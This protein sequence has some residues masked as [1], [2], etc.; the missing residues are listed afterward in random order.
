M[1]KEDILILFQQQKLSL[2]SAR[3]ALERARQARPLPLSAMQ[4][5]IWALQQGA[6]GNTAYQVPLVLRLR[7]ALDMPALEAA[8]LDLAL[9][10][11]ILGSTFRA[12]EGQPW[13]HEYSAAAPVIA[14]QA[15]GP[16]SDAALVQVLRDLKAAPL[17][18]AAGAPWRLHVL[19]LAPDEH[20]LMLVV[21]HIVYDGAS[22]LPLAATLLD[23]H[24][25]RRRGEL[26]LCVPDHAGFEEYVAAERSWMDSAAAAQALAYWQRQLDGELPILELPCD[27]PR[28]AV[29][30]SE[31]AV[32]SARLDDGV[33]AALAAAAAGAGV[34]RSVLFLAAFQLMLVRY[35]GQQDLVLGLPMS[36]RAPQQHG[37]VGNFI[38]MVPLRGAPRPD[39]IGADYLRRLQQDMNLARD[40]ARYPLAALVRHLNVPRSASVAPVFQAVF[41]YQNF[42]RQG[43]EAAFGARHQAQFLNIVHQE[44]EAD[45]GLEV[46]EREDA[47]RVNLKYSS[48]LFQAATADRMLQ[49]FLHLLAQLAAEPQRPMGD[50]DMLL[51]AERA[52]MLGAWNDTAA[53]CPE[54]PLAVL[55]EQQA[56]RQPDA[57]A[58]TA[59]GETL[60]Y[61]QLSQRSSALA[62]RLAGGAGRLVGVCM[63][64]S[65]D[66]L[67]ALLGVMKAG[68]AYVPIDPSYP[69]ERMRAI[70]MDSGA[71]CFLADA[72]SLPA[73]RAAAGA[74]AQLLDIADLGLD[75]PA[76]APAVAPHALAYVIYTSGTTG[77]PKGVMVPQRAL[78]NLL[79]SMARQPG[80]AAG[81]RMLALA[82]FAFDMSIPELFLP[83]LTGGHCILAEA[84]AARDPQRLMAALERHQPHLMQATPTTCAMLFEAGWRNPQGTMILCGAEALTE[85]VRQQLIDSG[86]VAWNMYGPTET[87][88]W[89]T[90]AP[91]GAGLPITLGRPLANTQVYIVDERMRLVPPGLDGELCIAGAGV[92]AGYLGQPE[93]SAGRFV[94][95]P[96]AG[97]GKLY[98]TGDI[99]RW[100]PDGQIAFVGR[101]DY[102][103][104]LRG[105]RIELEEVENRLKAHADVE[106]ALV[107]VNQQGKLRRLVAYIVPR[108]AVEP[109][110]LRAWL[111][112]ALPAY[113]V[114]SLYVDLAAIPLNSNG[115]ADRKALMA[116]PVALEAPAPVADGI[117]AE[118][119][120][121]WRRVLKLD[122]IGA[123]HGFFDV[124][125]DSLVAVELAAAISEGM[126]LPFSVTRLFQYACVR[127]I[128][129]YVAQQR[130]QAGVAAAGPAQQAA[131]PAPEADGLAIIGMSLQVP[132]ADSAAAFWSN[133]AAGVESVER[134]EREQLAALGLPAPLLQHERMVGVRAP[135]AHKHS[136]DAEFFGISARDA[137]LMD[138]QF[139]RLL[140]HA[141]LA[142]EDAGY[143]PAALRD[144][145]VFVSASHSEHG[146]LAAAAHGGEHAALDDEGDYVRWILSQGGSI[147]TMISHKLGL[148]GPSLYVHSNC[149]SSLS[150]L[151]AAWHSIRSGEARHALVAAATLYAQ[152]RVGYVHQRGLNFSSDGKLKAFDQDADGMVPGEGVVVL[153]VKRLADAIADDDH[154]YAAIRGVALNNDGADKAGYYAPS[155][156]GQSAVIEGLL[157]S[158]ATD[159]NSVVYVE[160][161]G[162]GTRIGDP[163]EVAALTAAY[164]RLG[165]GQNYC[166]LG[167]VK[168]NLGHLDTAAGLAGL[169]KVALSLYHGSLPPTL[170][171]RQANPALELAGS[172]FYIA[173]RLTPIAG[174]GG[175]VRAAVSAFG[176]GG[177]NGH[178]L[179][180]QRRR[181]AVPAPLG[182]ASHIVPLSAK[183]AQRLLAQVSQLESW[184]AT[185]AGQG[186]ALADI[187]ATLQRG[188]VAMAR[189]VALVAHSH[190]DLAAQLAALAG[191]GLAARAAPED[192]EQGSLAWT[193]WEWESGRLS[194]W[195]TLPAA[196]QRISL[197]GYPFEN[198]DYPPPRRALAAARLHPLLHENISTVQQTAFRSRFDG[199]EPFLRD[200]VLHGQRVLPGAAYLEMVREA[201]SRAV[202]ATG[203]EVSLR[204][205]VWL[206]PL[207]VTQASV[208]VKLA[209]KRLVDGALAFTVS[210][211]ADGAPYCQG[212][213]AV[214]APAAAAA[215][216]DLAHLR[217][218]CQTPRL[219]AQSCYRRYAQL[220]LR[221]GAAHRGVRQVWGDG[222]ELLAQL[223]LPVLDP[224]CMLDPGMLDSAFQ[225]T[226]AIHDGSAAQQAAVPFALEALHVHRACAPRMWAHIRFGPIPAAAGAFRKIDIDLYD[227]EGRLCAAVRQLAARQ[228]AVL[229]A[230]PDAPVL[231]DEATL[232]VAQAR[233]APLA[234][235][236]QPA[237][238]AVHRHVILAGMTAARAQRLETALQGRADLGCTLWP[239]GGAGVAA[240]LHQNTL[241]LVAWLKQLIGQRRAGAQLL[242]LCVE[243]GEAQWA[244][245]ALAAVLKSAMLEYPALRAQL[246]LLEDGAD[247]ALPAMLEQAA[248]QPDALQLRWRGGV[249]ERRALA[250]LAPWAAAP[251]PWRADGVYLITGA[252]GRIA[253]LLA[254]EIA[255]LARGATLVLAGR[256]AQGPR[257]LLDSL[258]QAGARTDYVRLALEDGAQVGAALAGVAA[259]H[260]GLHGVLHCAGALGDS[261]ILNKSEAEVARVLAPKVDGTLHLDA[262]TAA[263][264]LDLFLLFSS[265]G[266][267]LG[268]EGQADYCAANAFLDAFAAEREEWRLRG[269]RHGRS[270]SLG[271]PLWAEGGMRPD[272]AS[273][274]RIERQ[275]GMKPLPSQGAFAALY[276][277]L[278]TPHPS[279]LLLY[280]KAD[281]LQRAL[282]AAAAPAPLQPN[283]QAE[284][285]GKMTMQAVAYPPPAAHGPQ[286]QEAAED[287]F[288]ALLSDVLQTP[289]ARIDAQ[290]PLENYGID[291][292]I[293]VKLNERLEQVFGALSKTLFFEYQTLRAL[294]SYFVEA[295]RGALETLLGR[296]SAAAMPV[297]ATPPA[298][299][300]APA[301]A[302]VSATT[303]QPIP[304]PV[305]AL[306]VA[307]IAIVGL[308]GRYPGAET[309]DAFWRNLRDGVDSIREVPAE[310]WD[311]AAYFH[312]DPGHAGTCYTKWGGFLDGVDC[313][314]AGFFNISPREAAILDPQERV[315]LETAHAAIEDAGYTRHSLGGAARGRPGRVGV[316][317]G[318]MYQEYQLYGAQATAL[319]QVTALPSS[320]S[321][322]ANRVSY[323]CNFQ[324]PSM[325]VDTMCSS[326]LSAIHLA[327]QS[328]RLGE[329]SVALAGG[330]NLSI[331]PNKYL[332]LSLGKFASTKGR[333]ESFGAG[334]DG[335]VPG[336][337]VGAVVL[338]PLAHAL[339]DGDHIYGVIKGSALNHGGK[340]NGFSV[341]NPVAQADV[342]G[343][344]L[345]Q[346]ALAPRALDYIEAHGTGT[347]LGDPIEI[348]GL[349]K[350]F[351]AATQERQFC[352]IGSVKSNIGHCES[353]A[354]MAAL[355]KVL[356]QLR[357]NALAPSLHSAQLNPNIDFAASPFYVQR[358]LSAWPRPVDAASGTQRA[359]N[360]AISSFG[361]GGS[362][363]HL[364]VQEY[365]APAVQAAPAG[366]PQLIVLSARTAAQLAEQAGRLLGWLRAEASA[367]D[368]ASLAY[369]LQTGR[370]ALAHRYAVVVASPAQLAAALERC[371]A[372][373]PAA[374]KEFRHEVDGPDET[375]A[376]LG[377]DELFDQLV[378]GWLQAGRLDRLG[379]LWTRGLALNWTLLHPAGAPGRLSLP[380]YPFRRDRH[381][382]VPAIVGRHGAAAAP[383]AAALPAPVPA[384]LP[385]AAS[386]PLAAAM[387][388]AVSPPRPA[389]AAVPATAAA[390]DAAQVRAALRQSFAAALCMDEQDVK[391]DL[392]LVDMGMDSI[393]GVEW[394][395][396][397]NKRYALDLQAALI[398]DHPTIRAMAAFV[399]ARLGAAAP[400]AAAQPAARP[401]IRL[402]EPGATP[403]ATAPAALTPP[404]V[405]LQTAAAGA[406]PAPAALAAP[407]AATAAATAA[408]A[409]PTDAA[410]SQAAV[411][412]FL[413]ASLAEAL[414]LPQEEI[415]PHTALVDLGLDSIVG[416][417][418]MREVNRHFGLSLP[419]TAVYDHPSIVAL[420]SHV[421]ALLAPAAA[422]PADLDS[423]LRAVEQ[424]AIDV[425]EAD[426]RW[427]RLAQADGAAPQPESSV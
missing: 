158:T 172:P 59:Q 74:S 266:A 360:C 171:F 56:A 424:G 386:G 76:P 384:S 110:R 292:I 194:D 286:L 308:A 195:Q 230:A 75:R 131:R 299:A 33:A 241:A 340:T 189:R 23:Y 87:T 2:D 325:A 219:D 142:V 254:H 48:V 147:P 184:L 84:Q 423:L 209:F 239:A 192:A 341:P 228:L 218:R 371:S 324:G 406:A 370:E 93:L 240:R 148:T 18:L 136:F 375:L 70:A 79:A 407:V 328:L 343:L 53:A 235:A 411:R 91:I 183:S 179:L 6:P 205:V 311:H 104:K 247:A 204:N 319:G 126:G 253:A 12:A 231:E 404:P 1:K 226:I 143:V 215:A 369:T 389:P 57:P 316:Y 5:D 417:E 309:V 301:L 149:S 175:P 168:S 111:L 170:H 199:S 250:K 45:I 348:S 402:P 314:D 108:R 154:I 287:Y 381:W 140:Q 398:Y 9:R 19:Q 295:H 29:R 379:H 27:A 125:G 245:A 395:G 146:A 290:A 115:K 139:R 164:Q 71:A 281:L 342:I 64:R 376:M 31:G 272:A 336:E 165:A 273:L 243:A 129:Q 421:G 415:K 260:G 305:P 155:V 345:E 58:V 191:G 98:R 405:R 257:A 392:P 352:P 234:V 246:L 425:A 77:K 418:W 130:A 277:A 190:A 298:I 383:A 151:Y 367:P 262:A 181:A 94:D 41:S 42:A 10:F 159:P 28:P 248:A 426:A 278:A 420:A 351:A 11:P 382:G 16:L 419:A 271:W 3:L 196:G 81:Q 413:T 296:T 127:D 377:R 69:A 210:A 15:S 83:L 268:N 68:A 44:G 333:C 365:V 258:A 312:P 7:R 121:I 414:Y 363:A 37:A 364:I 214:A 50:C 153:L 198:V 255:R 114:P 62:S 252:G 329:C 43:E 229:P 256:A 85:R 233:W 358:E 90:M 102:Q 180:E 138:P 202:A 213:I 323:F 203:Q 73:L 173:E 409:R 359:R 128:A 338:K 354:G 122:G 306:A 113:A 97:A 197:P 61:A 315:F 293:V 30:S 174:A 344:A 86:S 302:A 72:A 403:A 361:A 49:H 300:L 95:D 133:L 422:E 60:S 349:S 225:A 206:R 357:H 416:V 251:A 355:S 166:G 265:A 400:P 107:V 220:G 40:H 52:L 78:V 270:L 261:F 177:T 284:T 291:S 8:C 346:A 216:L 20:I 25:Q 303:A 186:A 388:A 408:M 13:R 289:A 182:A 378:A 212:Q 322:I 374:G 350:V 288:K 161:H 152:E 267:F 124:G 294:A 208:D 236:P 54:Q 390:P 396:T 55:F 320:P 263:M 259:R 96:F 385:A 221:Y 92:T 304:A 105:Y 332:L 339:A 103:V 106:D 222:D 51:P 67:V 201:A 318:V 101:N 264:P 356:M 313:F 188:R 200:H 372:G 330:V 169:A 14:A 297:Q 412:T 223:E 32:V 387:P 157:R 394:V 353:A 163:I 99:A 112:A 274:R 119:L 310:R 410:P 283:E 82:T 393:V 285:A 66:L 362:N 307:D 141:W 46:F 217:A 380:T 118:V 347:S 269:R 232:L 22:T 176:V 276:A 193:A 327:C 227:D 150:A 47:C 211:L 4:R 280:G 237:P 224:G 36:N 156:G 39:E 279:L 63:E 401:A 65:T 178:A 321:S 326:S 244:Q 399:A 167:S 238:L 368:L 35:S 137:R 249:A 337:G 100:L 120:A 21:H 331:H 275:L 335:Y 282:E 123:E 135:V 24:E 373:Q 26:P 160:A 134:L 427:R 391:L 207:A 109:A 145:A 334:G 144:A 17:D 162:T 132:G 187:A 80:M 185:P 242:Q 89:S 366:A 397:I 88:V 34:N 38:N 117:E 317:V 116:L